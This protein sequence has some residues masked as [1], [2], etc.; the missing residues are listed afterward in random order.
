MEVIDTGI[1][2]ASQKGTDRQSCAFPNSCVLPSGRWL[3]CFRVASIKD[4]VPGQKVMLSYSD[5]LGKSWSEPYAPF[6]PTEV[7]GKLGSFRNAYSASFGGNRVSISM[8][9]ID[10]SDFSRPFFNEKTGGLWD[11]RIFNAS[12]DDG[13]QTWSKPS[14]VDTTPYN[15]PTAVTGH[16]LNLPNGELACQFETYNDYDDTCPWEFKSV[17]MFSSDGGKTWP[18]HV[19][20][21]AADRIYCWDQ[22]INVLA[23]GS[24]MGLFWTYDDKESKYLNIHARK[25]LD[26]GYTWSQRWDTGVPGQPGQVVSTL[27][28]GMVMPYV[29]RT[30]SPAIKM[31]KSIDGGKTWP[32][33]S[34]TLLYDSKIASQTIAKESVRGVWDELEEYSVG[35][36]A[37]VILAN[38][39]ILVTYYAGQ[40]K[41]RT[42][43]RWCLVKV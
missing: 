10:E 31:R 4:N 13:G 21:D 2:Y 12:S 8:Y 39:N 38:G 23:D 25:S 29:D 35:L 19:V 6:V 5:D 16:L 37:P 42:D 15:V 26:S 36:P 11:S 32:K 9:W 33:E 7:E 40:D 3:A 34:E 14:I 20:I 28:G 30:D 1:V 41:D 27:D 22:R 17:M 18:R 43:I 24:V